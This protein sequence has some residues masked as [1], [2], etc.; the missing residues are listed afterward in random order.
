MEPRQQRNKYAI[1][2]RNLAGVSTEVSDVTSRVEETSQTDLGHGH[3][4]ATT[5]RKGD[6][7]VSLESSEEQERK[8]QLVLARLR[9]RE[10]A[11][12][13][14]QEEAKGRSTPRTGPSRHGQRDPVHILSQR[15]RAFVTSPA[16]GGSSRE[17]HLPA[18]PMPGI[19]TDEEDASRLP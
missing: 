7:V 18:A 15:P 1:R 16:D 17:I 8:Q 12:N 5:P 4:S 14:K 2:A 11:R 3:G 6:M 19:E 10:R 9:R 13:D